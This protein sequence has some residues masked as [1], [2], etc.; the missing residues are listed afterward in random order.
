[1]KKIFKWLLFLT[2][3]LAVGIAVLLYNPGLVKGPLERYLSELAGY[4]ISLEGELKID[5]GRL[6][7][8]T[9]K[10]IQIS[11]PAWADNRD[12]LS[13]GNLRLALD[14]GSLF[15][16]IVIIDSLQVD[17]LQL[18]L[19]TD[20]NGMG[21]WISA[22]AQ[23]PE[24]SGSNKTGSNP[25]VIFKN[26]QLNNADFRYKNAEKGI[27]HV[28][29]IASLDQHQQ[30]DGMLQISLDG[31]FNSRLVELT[32]SIGPY[33][34][35]LGGHDVTFAGNGHFGELRFSGNGLVDD[36]MAPRR[37]QF[38]FEMQGP[39]IDEITAMLGIDD[40][41]AGGF[42]LRARGDEINDLYEADINGEIG[43]IRLS[44][45]AKV[46]DLS[47][48]NELDLNLS[49]NGPSLGSFTRVFG[50]ENWPDKP[51][52]LKADVDR[53]GGTL[54]ISNLTL[55]IGSTELILDAL[56]TNFPH[57]DASRI[58]LLISGDDVT[59][60]HELLG[61]SGLA[62]GPFE[63]HGKLDVSPQEVELIQV[64]VETS[65]GRATLS[66]TLG[67]AP[68]YVGSKLHLHLEGHN[69]RTMMSV[70]NIDALPEKSF[71]LDTRIETVEN[72]MLIER[73]VLVTIEDEQ[74]ELGGFLSFSPGSK[75]TDVE[76]RFS[77][78][79]LNR[80]L[81]RIVGDT[82]VP[83][84]PYNLSGR[85]RVV[86]EGFQLDNVK[87]ELNDIKLAA[88]GLIRPG[89]QFLGTGVDFQLSGDD[90]SALGNFAVI[91]DSLDIFV[92]GQSYQATGNFKIENN[93]WLLNGVSGRI[94]K[95]DLNF[96][97]LISNQPEWAGSNIH[98]F[99]KG[100]DLH[101]LL[102]DQDESDLPL[103][104]FE[105]NGRVLLSADT[106]SINEFSF[107]TARAHGQID[108]D[109]GWPIGSAIDAGFDVNIWGDDIR[110]LL[111]A[112]DA[113]EPAKAAYKIRAVGRK[114]GKL[115]SIKQ[116]NADIGNLQVKAKG[117]VDD[118]PANE[119]ADIA[120]SATSTDLSALGRLNG[121]HLPAMALEFKTDFKGNARR[122]VLN[123]F[124][125]TLGESHVTG[126]LDVSLEG[127]KPDIKLT[128]NSNYIDIRPLM[129][130]SGSED[131]TETTRN[132]T[133]LIPAIPLPLDA[134]ATADIDIKLNIV[135]LRHQGDSMKNIVIEAE[136]RAGSLRIPRLSL[137]GPRGAFRAA[138]SVIPTGAI[139]AGAR[140]ADV[141]VDLSAEKMVFNLS[142]QPQDKLSQVP[143]IDI[144]LHAS[145]KGGNLQE[146][147]GSI[148][149][150]FYLGSEGGTLEG[151][152]LS[153]LD[154]FILEEIFSL[155]TP[156]A[157]KKDDLELSCIA[158][159]LKITDGLVETDPALAFT[160]SKIT[161]IS[162]GTVDLKTEKMRLNFNAIPNNAL[163]ISASELFN[164]YILVGGTL[165]KPEVGLDPAKVLLHGSVAVGTA[166]ISILAKGLLDRVA[167][168][169]PLCE[170][171]LKQIEQKKRRK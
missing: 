153:V 80:V 147:A 138:L 115:I 23:P 130:L 140:I 155:I 57:L 123:N 145:G 44:V 116:F 42:S 73:G 108:L 87:A 121:D 21:N 16:D 69:A 86:E 28:L 171:M 63:I 13:I 152:D 110:H 26:I 165:S 137:Q 12:L 74:L 71:R 109:L 75:G 58:K 4:Q 114:R 158:T 90:F 79:H 104:A 77:G 133:R 144:E 60:F 81:Q 3:V 113:F 143:E 49:V 70:F 14:T 66:G 100:P 103:G 124:S 65:L 8:L 56:L 46:S 120:F 45:S 96:D 47:E 142:G 50:I 25:V 2:G 32:T 139:K 166:G 39:N 30:P 151:V 111:P 169:V 126:T 170:E 168:T 59:Q 136:T 29:H 97:S 9:A 64:E 19:E 125:A 18:D 92:P 33:A 91:G 22:N 135:E 101:A 105:T 24:D 61:I 38:T 141:K 11:A 162:K 83:D 68:S 94:G 131:E 93:G 1:M 89:D 52:N 112:K 128:A 146:V 76:V 34:N 156:K 127:S 134:L 118:K 119:T 107:E 35:L 95:T 161:L 53:L 43:D 154:T 99:I 5:P 157:D 37:P 106:L 163:K 40:L 27:E 7:V 167:N 41:G 132:Q 17:S 51:F 159:I 149:G 55:G 160:T 88:T 85:V 72:G 10:N 129:A 150:S 117:K 148:N 20:A 15:E 82:E 98:F 84:Q 164:P 122:F 67:A 6:S 54:N 48:L 31:D 36:L 102:A 62:T 78:Q